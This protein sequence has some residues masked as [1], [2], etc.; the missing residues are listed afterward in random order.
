MEPAVS[1]TGTVVDPEGRPAAGVWVTPLGSFGLRG[2]STRTDSAGKFTVKNVVCIIMPADKK[3][4]APLLGQ[5]FLKNFTHK[6]NGEA[7]TLVLTEVETPEADKPAPQ[8]KPSTRSTRTK[9]QN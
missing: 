8:P 1:L 9:R 2:Q 6:F 4:V 5:S 3:E 7:G